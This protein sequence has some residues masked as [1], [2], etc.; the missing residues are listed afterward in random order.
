MIVDQL[1][2]WVN[3][4]LTDFRASSLIM[5]PLSASL[6]LLPNFYQERLGQRFFLLIELA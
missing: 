1:S 6:L 4:N 3:H 5:P 2:I